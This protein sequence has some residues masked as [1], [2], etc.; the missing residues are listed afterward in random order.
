MVNLVANIL[1]YFIK[2]TRSFLKMDKKG[3]IKFIKEFFKGKAD[4]IFIKYNKDYINKRK[5]NSALNK[6][7]A[8]RDLD[9]NNPNRVVY[10]MLFTLVLLFFITYYVYIDIKENLKD[11][12]ISFKEHSVNFIIENPVLNKNNYI[13]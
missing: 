9:E 6:V 3:R 7:G 2:Y 8:Y 4:K 12:N 1:T 11:N 10:G 5:I 13:N